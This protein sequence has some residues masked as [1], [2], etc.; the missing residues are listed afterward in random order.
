MTQRTRRY[1]A[2]LNLAESK[3]GILGN[4]CITGII[5]LIASETSDSLKYL[6]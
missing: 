1:E 3:M 5:A 6:P 2:A 4:L